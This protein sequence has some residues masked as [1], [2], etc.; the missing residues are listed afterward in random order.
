MNNGT[1]SE[2][3]EN[4]LKLLEGFYC[5]CSRRMNINGDIH[6]SNDGVSNKAIRESSLDVGEVLLHS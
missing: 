3:Y 2:R 4:L 6:G 1:S 5:S